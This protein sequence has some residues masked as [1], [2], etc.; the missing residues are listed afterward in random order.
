MR[1]HG[2]ELRQQ[3]LA[4]LRSGARNTDVARRLGVP[5]GTV[6]YWLHMDRVRHGAAPGRPRRLCPR[7]DGRELDEDAYAYLLGLYLGDG[8]ISHCAQHRA[9]S[10]V[11]A[12]CDT[13][14]GLIEEAERAMR[15]V[16]PHNAIH[17]QSR[18]GCQC[19]KVYSTHLPCLF[20][21]HG[22][23]RKHQRS[24]RLEPWQQEI[25]DA[26]PWPLIRGL[27]HSDGTRITNWT[28][29]TVGGRP[30]R[31]EYPRYFFANTSEDILRIF[32][33]ALD[34]VG[35]EWRITRRSGRGLRNVSVA[36]RASVRLMD[37]HV[38]PKY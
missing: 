31:Y 19:V 6:G 34:R 3:A 4:L 20:P 13:W 38:G 35:V 21:Q 27:I 18:K 11:I 28:T 32:C 33:A 29:R 17:R 15:K 2:S 24:I 23:G 8:H 30:K 25:V 22:P 16:L 9:P 14:P 1:T 5:E 10:L 36:R 12:C 7:C 26:R 37:E